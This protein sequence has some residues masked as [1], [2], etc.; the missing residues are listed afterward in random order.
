MDNLKN[1]N[2]SILGGY[3][4][5]DV[6]KSSIKNLVDLISDVLLQPTK[7]VT[8]PDF[9]PTLLDEAIISL[10]NC[11]NSIFININGGVLENGEVIEDNGN[12]NIHENGGIYS[13]FNDIISLLCR[14]L[15]I[16]LR[17]P[18]SLNTYLI[19]IGKDILPL[20][21]RYLTIIKNEI[22]DTI[23]DAV[24]DITE[25]LATFNSKVIQD[26]FEVIDIKNSK[27]P[28]QLHQLILENPIKSTEFSNW[29]L[30]NQIPSNNQ[31]ERVQFNAPQL[32]E[33]LNAKLINEHLPMESKIDYEYEKNVPGDGLEDGPILSTQFKKAVTYNDKI[34]LPNFESVSLF[35][36][37]KRKLDESIEDGDN[38][39]NIKN[40]DISTLSSTATATATTINRRQS[41]RSRKY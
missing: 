2:A 8:L 24:I 3:D 21:L 15:H 1:L 30:L 35:N 16:I 17:S 6:Y 40:N 22:F 25:R 27:L 28:K 41:N 12:I 14:V 4:K 7:S 19:G 36:E 26:S 9:D 5:C 38:D 39:D 29:E 31:Y 20:M 11:F 13:D 10:K 18:Q 32:H 23:F 37:K 34:A 33:S